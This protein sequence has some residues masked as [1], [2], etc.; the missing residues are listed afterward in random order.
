[1]K[2]NLHPIRPV[3]VKTGAV[4]NVRP[5]PNL[6]HHQ[7]SGQPSNRTSKRLYPL[8]Q[9]AKQRRYDDE[10]CHLSSWHRAGYIIVRDE[11]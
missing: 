10:T 6:L 2:A 9:V 11:F 4:Q 8:A 3:W 5:A 7:G 1:M